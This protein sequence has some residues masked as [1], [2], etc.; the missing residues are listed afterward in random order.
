MLA[1]YEESQFLPMILARYSDDSPRLILADYLDESP[2]PAHQARAELIRIQC[3]LARLAERHPRRDELLEQQQQIL[4][5]YQ[6]TWA[7][8]LLDLVSG[9]EFRRGMLDVVSMVA[10]TFITHGGKLFE[11][12]AIRRIKLID[13]ASVLSRLV[14]SPHLMQV[15]ELDLCGNDLGNGGVNLLLRS[16]YLGEVRT[17]DLSF[18]D[19]CDGG[20]RLLAETRSLPKLRELILSDNGR[21]S[22]DGLRTLAQSP[23]SAGLRKMDVSNNDINDVGIHA[24][25]RSHHLSELHTVHIDNNHIGDAGVMEL[26]GSALLKRMLKQGKKLDLRRNAITPVGGKI[27][28]EASVMMGVADLDL[29]GNYLGDVGVKH[30]ADSSH[31]TQL[32]SLSLGQNR[33]SDIGAKTLARSMLMPKLRYLDLASNR[34]TEEGIESIYHSRGDWRTTLDLSDNFSASSHS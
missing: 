17:L 24:L 14:N 15:R 22:G 1:E 27:L 13:A 33:I 12:A 21:I 4:S 28:A 2:N 26:L 19:I 30:L 8:P 18:N 23:F 32:H 9:I 16:P 10:N 29:S 7:K 11:R 6:E 31:L 3:T 34:L 20:V 5:E 25:T